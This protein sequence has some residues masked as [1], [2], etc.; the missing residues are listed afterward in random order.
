MA[1]FNGDGKTD[2]GMCIEENLF[3]VW[4]YNDGFKATPDEKHSF[5]ENIISIEHVVNIAATDRRSS[6]VL[7]G[8]TRVF[9]LYAE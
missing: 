6:I 4:L 1:D 7:R 3:G 8:D 9:A 2:L 5:P